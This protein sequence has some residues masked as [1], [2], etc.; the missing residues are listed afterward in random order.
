MKIAIAFPGVHRKGGV[1]RVAFECC[2]FLACR[3]H[4]VHVVAQE[5]ETVAAPNIHCHQIQKPRCPRLFN[6]RRFFEL[7]TRALRSV[8]HDVLNTHGCVCPIGGV[9]WVQ[10]IHAS[11]LERAKAF[12]A[13]FS[14]A[15]IKQRLN[16]VHPMLLKLEAE[17]FSKR[18]YRKLIATTPQVVEDL[19]HYYGV[20]ASDVTII[21]NGFDPGEFNPN[22][23][24]ARRDEMRNRLGL[25]ND[26]VV[27]L[28]VANELR[29]KGYSV[30]LN[31]I[32]ILN[33]PRIRLLVVGRPAKSEV[34]RWAIRAGI[35]DQVIALGPSSD[36]S[37]M[38][39]ASDVMVLPTQYEAFSLAILESLGS[40][41]PVVTS[42]IPGARD[43]IKPGVNG[44]LISNPLD[45][46][47]LA[48]ALQPFL[49]RAH[50][51]RLSATTAKTVARYQWS[52]I[53]TKFESILLAS[54]SH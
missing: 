4:E 51:A 14:P 32:K 24:A 26:H 5:W 15:R 10:S 18:N 35:G 21:P 39:A 42:D 23:C 6:G 25:S 22:R 44:C 37:G 31:A 29:R 47:E 13:P 8:P 16:P 46:E 52:N 20:P 49:E 27:L 1:E 41:L 3:G 11:W 9:Q 36:V 40:G 7:A 53:L 34:M 50:V 33:E 2:R 17:H 19:N 54:G 43:A 48:S 45:G 38:H 28:F 30:V 12:R